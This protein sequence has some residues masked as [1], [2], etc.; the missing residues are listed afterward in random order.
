MED[1]RPSSECMSMNLNDDRRDHILR[2]LYER[3][4]TAQGITAIPIGIQDLRREMKARHGMKQSEVAAN[5]D[6]LIQ[7]GWV[8]PEVKS[9]SFVTGGGMV[10][11][12]EQ[13]KY[14]ISDV[15]INHLEAASMFKKP[16]AASQVNTTNVQGVTVVGDGNVVNAKFTEVSAALDELDRAIADARQLTDEQKLDAAGD[17]SAIRAQVAKK[18]PNPSVIR[19]AWEGL[20]AL[21]VL[22][23]A[24][25]AIAKVGK[26]LSGLLS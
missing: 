1:V 13:T 2:F 6:Y 18:N 21:P 20:K 19:G 4:Q 25:D 14:K 11:Q 23:S 26:L 24:A 9:R 8:R 15:G 22:G 12:R 17:I 7:A 5:L 3:H 10:L 16:Q